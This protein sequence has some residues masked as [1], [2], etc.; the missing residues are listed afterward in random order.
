MKKQILLGIILLF[1]CKHN[2]SQSNIKDSI[3]EPKNELG[4]N[5]IPFFKLFSNSSFQIKR[6]NPSILY[7]RQIKPHLYLG[8]I[9]DQPDHG[10]AYPTHNPT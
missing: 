2:Y 1:I 7:K 8:V 10:H 5:L 6:L 9:A 3:G 4:T